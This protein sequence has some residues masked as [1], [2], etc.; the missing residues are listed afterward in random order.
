MINLILF[1]ISVILSALILPLGLTYALVKS[2]IQT[3]FKKILLQ[4]AIGIDKIGNT[5]C[6]VFLNDTFL[7]QTETIYLFGNPYETISSVLGKNQGNSDTAIDYSFR[8]YFTYKLNFT[9]PIWNIIVFKKIGFNINIIYIKYS[10]FTLLGNIVSN[11]LDNIDKNHCKN[12][13]I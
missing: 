1:I 3:K 8:K 11:F 7:K 9:I 4:T 13:V 2:L 6:E 10:N 12:S 5:V